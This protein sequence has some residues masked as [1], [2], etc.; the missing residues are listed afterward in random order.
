M[1]VAGGF[2]LAVLAI[3]FASQLGGL[4]EDDRR[5]VQTA[6]A[7]YSIEALAFIGLSAKALLDLPE[8]GRSWALAA[9][10]MALVASVP[11]LASPVGWI[12]AV[13]GLVILALTLAP[14]SA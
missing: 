1:L 9:G 2:V 11:F 13:L 3:A 10:V 5:V 4:D 14:E 7:F 12:L 6:I 8:A